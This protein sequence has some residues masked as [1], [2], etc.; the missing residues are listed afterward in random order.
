M[1]LKLFFFIKQTINLILLFQCTK[2]LLNYLSLVV[3]TVL[4]PNHIH[5]QY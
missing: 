5:N 1:L 2:I 3:M 4:N